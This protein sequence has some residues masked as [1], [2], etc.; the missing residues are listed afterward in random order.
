MGERM[1]ERLE[2]AEMN[3]QAVIAKSRFEMPRIG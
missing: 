2:R 1:N 3:G